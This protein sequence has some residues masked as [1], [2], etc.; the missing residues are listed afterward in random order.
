MRLVVGFTY[1]DENRLLSTHIHAHAVIDNACTTFED[2]LNRRYFRTKHAL[3][4][5]EDKSNVQRIELYSRQRVQLIVRFRLS[6]STDPEHKKLISTNGRGPLPVRFMQMTKYRF[7]E[8]GVEGYYTNYC[9][10]YKGLPDTID[11]VDIDL[12]NMSNPVDVFQMGNG[13]L[14]GKLFAT[15]INESAEYLF[16]STPCG[17]SMFPLPTSPEY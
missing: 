17:A 8:E 12:G 2:N 11:F 7:F 16:R 6:D 13:I 4:P 15:L 10:S 9:D 1:P 5:C 14:L 3:M